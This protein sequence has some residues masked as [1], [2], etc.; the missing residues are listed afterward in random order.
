MSP[1]DPEQY[2]QG[3]DGLPV[4]QVGSWA[5]DKLKLLSDY[6]YASGGARK[7]YLSAGA[8][9]IDPFCGPGRSVIRRTSEYIDG[10]PIAAF[11]RAVESAG[12]FTSINISDDDPTCSR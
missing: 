2:T 3:D 11:K 4:E 10:S 1:R 9:F 6:V 7:K 8:A 12:E 5:V